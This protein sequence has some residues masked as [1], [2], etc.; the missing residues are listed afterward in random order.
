SVP[1]PKT[2]QRAASITDS[3][4]IPRRALV[5]VPKTTQRAALI[6]D[7]AAISRRALVQVPKTT[8]R[9][10]LV[11]V[12]KTTQRQASITDSATISRRALVQ[13]PKTT[14]RAA[15]IADLPPNPSHCHKIFCKSQNFGNSPVWVV[16]FPIYAI[17][18]Y[19]LDLGEN[20]TCQ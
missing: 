16:I 19:I 13:V 10:A 18:T 9:A 1:V 20:K 17:I 12:P 3:A 4:A 5:Q 6:T 8:K 14:Q 15:S 7:S 11:P 2:T